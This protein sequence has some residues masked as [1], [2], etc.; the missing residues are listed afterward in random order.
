MCKSC[1]YGGHSHLAGKNWKPENDNLSKIDFFFNIFQLT[2]GSKAF[3]VY[4][5]YNTIYGIWLK[6]ATTRL[7]HSI[8]LEF[9]FDESDCTAN[10][11]NILPRFSFQLTMLTAWFKFKI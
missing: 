2:N 5:V 8:F 9:T 3:T 1:K 10:K 4:N 6:L 11:Q 7:P